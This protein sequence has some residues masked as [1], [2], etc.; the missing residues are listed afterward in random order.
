MKLNEEWCH[1]AIFGQL[2]D[3]IIRSFREAIVGKR[4]EDKLLMVIIDK[5]LNC[6]S[7]VSNLCTKASQKTTCSCQDIPA[8][9]L[10][11][12]RLAINSFT[13]SQFSY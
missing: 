13:E 10:D 4:L 1:L 2:H 11:T 6:K 5:N 7:H 8:H 9:D 12:M 3:Y